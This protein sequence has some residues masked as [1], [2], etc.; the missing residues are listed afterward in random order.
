MYF[1]PDFRFLC[2]ES[3]SHAESSKYF[4]NYPTVSNSGLGEFLTIAF[5]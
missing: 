4:L 3:P 5:S 1:N 2:L